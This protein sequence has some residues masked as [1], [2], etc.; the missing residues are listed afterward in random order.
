MVVQADAAT[1]QCLQAHFFAHNVMNA[2]S[3]GGG[4]EMWPTQFSGSMVQPYGVAGLLSLGGSSFLGLGF[5]MNTFQ[6]T[7]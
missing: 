2:L 1:M 3:G 4:L 6:P 7:M 5:G